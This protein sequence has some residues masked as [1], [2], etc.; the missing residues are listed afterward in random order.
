MELWEVGIWAI[1]Q[2][3]VSTCVCMCVYTG[4]KWV[5]LCVHRRAEMEGLGLGLGLELGLGLGRVTRRPWLGYTTVVFQTFW[6]FASS[7]LVEGR[8]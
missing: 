8:G 4:L 7:P 3:A 5:P 6:T 1:S 2:A